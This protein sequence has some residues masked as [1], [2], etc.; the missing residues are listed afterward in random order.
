MGPE[1][2]QAG[3][4]LIT[5]NRS[6]P[7]G[8]WPGGPASGARV[9]P[10]G[11]FAVVPGSGSSSLCKQ[12]H[13]EPAAGFTAHVPLDTSPSAPASVSPSVNFTTV[14]PA[15]QWVTSCQPGTECH[16]PGGQ[17]GPEPALTKGL[18]L[19]TRSFSLCDG[20]MGTAQ[21]RGGLPGGGRREDTV[22]THAASVAGRR[23][24]ELGCVRAAGGVGTAAG[25]PLWCACLLSPQLTCH[26]DKWIPTHLGWPVR[27]L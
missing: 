17:A 13:M 22:R 15:S 14:S 24:G 1:S 2:I 5:G 19:T 20:S 6:S 10:F 21:P 11:V 18:T 25:L 23:G 16:V 27:P 26:E 7:L 12:L 8:R 3:K 9:S 4:R